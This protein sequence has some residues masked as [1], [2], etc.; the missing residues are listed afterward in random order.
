MIRNIVITLL[1]VIGTVI[2]SPATDTVKFKAKST[3]QDGEAVMLTGKL[4]KKQGDGPF[5]AGVLLHDSR[6]PML[7]YEEPWVERLTCWG[8]VTF[9][10]RHKV[11]FSIF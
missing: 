5:P 7:E 8:Y 4:T 11:I 3:T 2:S 1:L 9:L 10:I 6:G